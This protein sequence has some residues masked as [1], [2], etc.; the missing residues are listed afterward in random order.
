MRFYTVRFEVDIIDETHDSE[1]QIA[2]RAYLFLLEAGSEAVKNAKV[3]R[4]S[5]GDIDTFDAPKEEIK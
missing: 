1:E 3:M 2:K 4:I 5:V